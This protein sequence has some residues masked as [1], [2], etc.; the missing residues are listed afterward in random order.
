MIYNTYEHAISRMLYLIAAGYPDSARA[1][2][3]DVAC[4]GWLRL[5][6]RRCSVTGNY[7]MNPEDDW[8]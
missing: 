1:V 8:E 2:A 5:G 4:E 6:R 7:Y 3:R